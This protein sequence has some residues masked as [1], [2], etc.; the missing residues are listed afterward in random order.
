[1][2][3]RI[4]NHKIGIFFEYLFPMK[5]YLFVFCCFVIF[6]TEKNVA[7]S[8]Q[9][10]WSGILM[11]AG[12]NPEKADVIYLSIEE[13]ENVI[14]GVTRIELSSDITEFAA[15]SFKGTRQGNKLTISE[16]LIRRSSK[17]RKSP[18]CKLN[19]E[20]EFDPETKYLKG[21][22]VSTD[23]RNYFGEVVLFRSEHVV[24][25][26]KEPSSTHSWKNFFIRN[27]LKG[28]PAPEV[29]KKEQEEFVFQPIYFDHDKSEIKPEFYEY[30]NRMARVVDGIHD[31]RIK[32]IGHTDAVGTDGYNMGLSER[33]ADAIRAY[34]K[35]QGIRSEKLDIDF[36]GKHQ[37]VSDNLSREGKQKNRRVVFE[38]AY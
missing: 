1:M 24:N 10:S 18:E 8:F 34:F 23:C 33:R 21:K 4:Q 20:L 37:P 27:Y 30:L 3:N 26:E 14:S 11:I 2:I 31:L 7:Q 16:E 12:Q 32:I 19:Y 28:Y 35:K 5:R 13:K 9:G 38:F 15:K 6:A 36:K 25:L 17:T 29:L 22:V